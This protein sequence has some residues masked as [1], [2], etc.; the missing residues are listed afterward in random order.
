MTYRQAIQNPDHYANP[1]ASPPIP[2]TVGIGQLVIDAQSRTIWLGVEPAVDADQAILVSDIVALLERDEEVRAD[3]KTYTDSQVA[4]RAPLSHTHTSSQITDFVP[5]VTAV[6]DTVPSGLSVGMI[7]CWSGNKN[8][9]GS[10]VLADWVLCAGQAIPGP[11]GPNVPDL[12]DRMI[13]GLNHL[14]R[15]NLYKNPITTALSTFPAGQHSHGAATQGTAITIEQM[16]WHNHGGP[17]YDPGHV[18]GVTGHNH[19]IPGNVWNAHKSG[20]EAAGFGLAYASG[21]FQDRVLIGDS[22][23][24]DTANAGAATDLRATGIHVYGQGGG[25]AHTH[26]IVADGQHSHPLQQTPEMVPYIMLAFIIKVR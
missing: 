15:D 12:T 6:I 20:S 2:G 5:A 9:I 13:M 17:V 11:W 22:A 1:L 23:N 4:L 10:G 25:V 18:H 7:V 8:Q 26:P 24:N 14:A 21:F 19:G 16:P 3:C